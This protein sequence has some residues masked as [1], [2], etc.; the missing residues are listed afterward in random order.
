[1]KKRRVVVEEEGEGDKGEREFPLVP[2]LRRLN[3]IPTPPGPYS[4]PVKS[5]EVYMYIGC[6]VLL[7]F[8]VCLTLLA[9]FLL[10]HIS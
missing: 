8:V 3:Q 6:A 5:G 1:M 2:F 4:V 9:F 7:C 10:L